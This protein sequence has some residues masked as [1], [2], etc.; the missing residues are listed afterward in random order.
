MKIFFKFNNYFF[1]NIKIFYIKKK[2]ISK[3]LNLK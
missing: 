3:N 1:K 2:K